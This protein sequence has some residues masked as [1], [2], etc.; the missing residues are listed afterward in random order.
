M[1]S[2]KQSAENARK[3]INDDLSSFDILW[4]DL[5]TKVRT[6]IVDLT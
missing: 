4:F 2:L 5:Q 1:K 3:D 6:L